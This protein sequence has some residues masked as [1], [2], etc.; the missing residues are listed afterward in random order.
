MQFPHPSLTRELLSGFVATWRLWAPLLL[1]LIWVGWMTRRWWGGKLLLLSLGVLI[2]FGATI[3]LREE[4][5][6]RATM[7]AWNNLRV[8]L[9]Q[10]SRIDGLQLAAGTMVRWNKEHQGHLLTVEFGRGQE[11]SPGV[12]LVGNADHLWEETWRGTLAKESELRGWKCA[13][14]KRDIH[15]SG[16][17]GWCVLAVPQKITAGEVPAGTAVLLDRG[18]PSNALLH[19]PDVGM[20]ANPG[21]FWIA[22]HG[23]FALYSN[24][25]LLSVPGPLNRRGVTFD[26]GVVLRYG[27]EDVT[28]WYG[29]GYTD[30]MPK[31]ITGPTAPVT[32]W[33]GDLG[34]PLTCEGGRKLDKGSRVTVPISG[35]A[36]TA[37]HWDFSAPRAK[38]VIDSLHCD[39]GPT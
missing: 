12:V 32:G 25:E 38:Q 14:G 39:L 19:L 18:D 4:A 33:R 3:T 20:R 29:Y 8:P 21:N 11:V 22:P 7:E 27:D 23:W 2:I 35:D 1:L 30:Q 13:A 36:V 5:R 37:T 17:L 15:D 24:G 26:S 9:A 10:A 6:E 16:E 28:R 31:T 34:T